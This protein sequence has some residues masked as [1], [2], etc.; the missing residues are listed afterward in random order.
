MLKKKNTNFDFWVFIYSLWNKSGDPEKE[1]GKKNPQK[2]DRFLN[3]KKNDNKNVQIIL[4]KC[5][6]FLN[7]CF[8]PF[9]LK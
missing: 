3:I 8:A 6:N 7:V 9:L 2:T 4:K 1:F 5:F